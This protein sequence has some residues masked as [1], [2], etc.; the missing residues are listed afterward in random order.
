[1]DTNLQEQ[2]LLLPTYFQGHLVLTLAALG[3]GILISIPIGIWAAQSTYAKQPLLTIVGI[4]QTIPSVAILALVVALLGGQIG[5]VPAIIA[6]TLYC[7]LPIVRNTVTGLETVAADVVE[8]AKGIGMSTS[9]ILI[10]VKLPL[11]MPVII[12]GIRT[13][14]VWTVGLATLSTLVGATSFGNYIFTGLQT[15]NLVSVTVGS[16]AA[17]VMAI[18]LDLFIGGIQWLAENA[19]A[20]KATPEFRRVKRAVIIAAISASLVILYTLRPTPQADYIVG[21]KGFT[22]QYILADLISSELKA[23]GFSVDQR[24]GMGTQVIYEALANNTIDVY[25]EYSGTVWANIM[26]RDNNP[27]S[28]RVLQQ[29]SDYVL[30]NDQLVTVGPLGFKNLYAFAMTKQRAE[31]LG[32]SS[33]DDLVPMADGL[34]AGGDLEFFG[35]PEWA[36]VRDTYDLDFAEKLTFDTALMYTAVAEGQVDIISAYST[37]GRIA[38][39]ELVLLEDPRNAMLPYDSL[40]LASPLAGKDQQLMSLM[41]ALTNRIS[42]QDMQQANKIVDVDGGTISDAAAYLRQIV[43][44]KP[45]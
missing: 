35:R 24:L 18:G 42:D 25:V 9:Q 23:A 6:L 14:A 26:G 39:Y 30:L 2:L 11:A 3:I 1:M 8:A 37:D 28:Q 15:R 13:A 12:A 43:R 27:G 7:M 38:A 29:V 4:I 40:L 45:Y 10:K 36:T 32:I 34:V 17:A 41:E 31:E 33:I 19:A 16:I 22:E 20:K 5:V 44:S 21:G